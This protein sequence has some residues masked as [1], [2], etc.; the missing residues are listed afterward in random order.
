M[1]AHHAKANLLMT[2]ARRGGSHGVNTRHCPPLDIYSGLIDR[3]LAIVERPQNRGKRN[4]YVRMTEAGRDEARR[5]APSYDMDPD[6]IVLRHNGEEPRSAGVAAEQAAL[7]LERARDLA[8][9]AITPEIAEQLARD[10]IRQVT[11]KARKVVHAISIDAA[12]DHRKTSG[13]I[14]VR[15]GDGRAATYKYKI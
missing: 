6:Q 4:T 14:E 13:K 2:L 11:G 9:D 15:L 8:I 7:I 3:G 1:K 5:L 12:S 10:L